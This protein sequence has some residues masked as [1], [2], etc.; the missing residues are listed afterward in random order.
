MQ[1]ILNSCWKLPSKFPKDSL[2]P[3]TRTSDVGVWCLGGSLVTMKGQIWTPQTSPNHFIIE[4]QAEIFF[5]ALYLALDKT[6][7][8]RL[9]E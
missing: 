7:K 8:F 9:T 2:L 5:T 6:Q 1:T 4:D 3:V